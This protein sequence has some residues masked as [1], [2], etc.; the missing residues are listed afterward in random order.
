[1]FSGSF[2]LT[3]TPTAG[4]DGGVVLNWTPPARNLWFNVYQRDDTAGE[5][6]FTLT[7]RPTPKQQQ[8]LDLIA[9]IAL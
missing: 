4:G 9:A 1:M 6:A 2:G 7:T 8:A 3:A 5:A